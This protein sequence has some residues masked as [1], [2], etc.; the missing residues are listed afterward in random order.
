[1]RGRSRQDL[2]ITAISMRLPTFDVV[3]LDLHPHHHG[4]PRK[5]QLHLPRSLPSR[6]GDG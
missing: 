1:M 5:M 3:V 4:P 2:D 6:V